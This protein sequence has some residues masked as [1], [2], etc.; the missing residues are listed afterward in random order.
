MPARPRQRVP[1]G[2]VG[3]VGP[4]PGREPQGKGGQ[5]GSVSPT[6]G[7]SGGED[8][9]WENAPASSRS[10]LGSRCHRV[11]CTLM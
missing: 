10:P 9:P 7:G 5:T 8:G 4:D 6:H 11:V 1:G 2:Q 3:G